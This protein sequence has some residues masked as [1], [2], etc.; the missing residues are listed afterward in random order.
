MH[1]YALIPIAA[2]ALAGCQAPGKD[3]LASINFG[4]KPTRWQEAIREYLEPR[5]PDLK[6]AIVTFRAEPQQ[7]LQR[8]T[9]VRGRQWGWATCVWIDENHPRGHR[10][11][12]PMTFFFRD[13]K[14]ATINGGP[15]DA[16]VVGAKYAREQCE[17]LGAPFN[18]K[19]PDA[20]R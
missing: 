15:D 6:T 19:A 10:G 18:P 20:T 16:N 13:D 5:I 17:K 7:M 9:A 14:I 2:L 12:Y 11:T 8:E 3:E 1:R 4:P